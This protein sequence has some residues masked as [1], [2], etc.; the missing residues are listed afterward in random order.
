[1]PEPLWK[2][3]KLDREMA[4]YQR[5]L[6]RRAAKRARDHAEAQA[7]RVLSLQ[8]EA[9]DSGRCRVCQREAPRMTGAPDQWGQAH[10]IV[11]RSAGGPDAL[12]NLVWVCNACSEQEHRHM[13]AISGTADALVV[14]RLR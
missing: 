3:S 5:T 1:M 7:W 8:V 11:Y 13:M 14:R 6:V 9:R 12:S 10:H 4:R 2:P